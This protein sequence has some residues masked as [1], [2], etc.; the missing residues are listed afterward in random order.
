MSDETT[1]ILR[2]TICGPSAIGKTCL[3][4]R[5][6]TTDF[7]FP[8]KPTVAD[9][10][11][12]EIT[13]GKKTI[14]LDL[15]DSAGREDLSNI[16]VIT[17]MFTDLFFLCF[18]IVDKKTLDEIKKY[19]I[20]ELNNYCPKK[21]YLLVGLKKDLRYYPDESIDLN[22]IV[23]YSEGQEFAKK[24]N[25]VEYIECSAKTGENCEILFEYAGKYLLKKQDKTKR[26]WYYLW[27]CK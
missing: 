8:Y 7:K 11:T 3:I 13:I 20:I 25:A 17:Y 12:K 21:P 2:V 10:F 14:K 23:S 5:S 15:T 6:Q 24:I 4:R 1:N 19:W 27:L 9:V 26:K 18:S 16:R 22:E